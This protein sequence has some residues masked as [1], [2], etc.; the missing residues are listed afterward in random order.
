MSI[1]ANPTAI[2]LFL[3]GGLVL[4]V[5][6]TAA[7]ASTTWLEKRSTFI[8]FFAESV[9]GLERGAPVKFQGVPV[10]S[11]TQ[12]LIQIDERDKTF[13][14]PVQYEIDLTRLTTQLETFVQLDDASVLRQQIADGLRA[15]LQM[16]SIVTGQLYIELTYRPDAAP[17]QFEARPTAWPE[18]PTTPS[19]LAALGT[20]AGSLMADVL[21]ILFQVNEMLE[22]VNMLEINAAVVASAQAVERLVE[23]PEIRVALEQVPGMNAQINRTMTELE[24]LAARANA[25]I[26][27]LQ[28]QVEGTTA[29]M[30]ATL[31]V[32]RQTLEETHG[33]FSAD[34]GIGYGLQEALASLRDA[35][36]ALRLLAMS[37]EQSPDML[38]RGRSAPE[39]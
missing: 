35:A 7:L 38:I 32:L 11:V 36:D 31:H 20:G 1:R 25:A 23:T 14:V 17:G 21:K 29:E 26:D 16:E 39:N 5:G 4:A 33:L 18:I 6:G 15:Q 10:G 13:Q 28:L 9:N 2:G 30:V 12:I 8:S 3:I 27:P 34:S 37:L 22:E 19:L 24:L